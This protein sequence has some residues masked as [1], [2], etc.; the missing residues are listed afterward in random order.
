MNHKN[1]L[2]DGRLV[3]PVQT[4][5]SDFR[6]LVT[7]VGRLLGD[8]DSI[9][10]KKTKKTNSLNNRNGSEL[11]ISS[12]RTIA[13]RFITTRV[14][15]QALFEYAP[16]AY[17]ELDARGYILRTN[18]EGQAMFNLTNGSMAERSLCSFVSKED[19]HVVRQH[20]EE[21]KR[22][23]KTHSL[24]IT[25]V[26]R[27]RSS[28]M[29]VEIYTRSRHG[30]G[31]KRRGYWALIFRKDGILRYGNG[32]TPQ[33]L[34]KDRLHMLQELTANLNSAGT[35]RSASDAFAE[36][37]FK[38]F[39]CR[40][41]VVFMKRP[42]GLSLI[43]S[44]ASGRTS[45]EDLPIK[46]SVSGPAIH[47]MRSGR[48]IFWTL[49]QRR[50]L[51]FNRYLRRL[52]PSN[53][54]QSFAFL[55]LTLLSGKRLGVIALSFPPGRIFT[56]SE[57]SEMLMLER[58]Y[59][60]ALG[61]AWLYEEALRERVEAERANQFKEEFLAV[62]SHELKNPLVPILGW[63]AELSRKRLAPEK[64]VKAV[65]SIVRNAKALSYLIDDLLD[66]SRLQ[67]G[68]LRLDCSAIRMQDIAREAIDEIGRTAEAKGIRVST[69]ISPNIPPLHADPR[70]ILQVL[71]NLINNAV[72]FTPPGGTVALKVS[73]H[74]DWVECNVSD[75][76][77][78]ISPEFLP[79]VFDRFRQQINSPR[80]KP[81][82]LGLGL[83]IVRELVELHGGT[84]KAQSPGP[85]QGA[86]FTVR[87]PLRT[88]RVNGNRQMGK[89][90]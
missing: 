3:H 25:L 46:T 71:V 34:P 60:E 23:T 61:R 10:Q 32:T 19:V 29:P 5:M 77:R 66:V 47:V 24:N 39:G 63:S 72:K 2:D 58:I 12:L 36:H 57:R 30:T 44:F 41:G 82:G 51:I 78:G 87:L 17:V 7:D 33:E 84:V 81:A 89:H 67:T 31:D 53:R 90:R 37:C 9:L 15:Y 27:G 52:P 54:K 38:A 76:G 64:Q 20:L 79:F 22:D 88:P 16:A 8:V 48:P 14:E 6:R 4:L 28:V 11:S 70:R 1:Q 56:S 65:D 69:E 85:D 62:A 13:T 83:A 68:K 40:S 59:A 49:S 43:A 75:S 42:G 21:C 35:M 50:G 74:G 55:P 80:E 18:S 86:T 73:R 45:A 26:H